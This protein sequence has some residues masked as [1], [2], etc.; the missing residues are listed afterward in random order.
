[1]SSKD[2]TQE[3]LQDIRDRA[4]ERAE[5]LMNPLWKRAYLRL[6]DAADALDA[7]KARTIDKDAD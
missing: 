6:A 5:R 3:E 7:M 2:F 4:T 1:M